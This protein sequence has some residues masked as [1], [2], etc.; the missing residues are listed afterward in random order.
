MEVTFIMLLAAHLLAD[1]TLQPDALIKR[2]RNVLYL[3]L[4]MLIVAGVAVLILGGFPWLLLGI[5]VVTH[6]IMDAIKVY[7]LGDTLFSFV[8]DQSVHL[9]VIVA[10]AISFPTQAA[11]WWLRLPQ[12]G[13]LMLI[14][15]LVLV[16]GLIASLQVGAILIRKATAGFT[17]EIEAHVQAGTERIEGLKNGGYYIGMLERA[18]VM[19]L[20]L[21]GQIAGVGFLI[22][23]KSILRFGDVKESHQRKMTE[24]IIIGTFLSFGWGVLIAALT[25]IGLMHYWVRLN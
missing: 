3:G 9:L 8:I 23:A 5:L 11:S 17:D 4:H 24:Y 16:C 14:C 15:A 7:I 13:Q 10:L 22:A 25:Q 19:L 1:F 18:L 12:N 21:M 6:L 20:V 2:K